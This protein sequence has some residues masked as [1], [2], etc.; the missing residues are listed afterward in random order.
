MM[1]AA[2]VFI[3]LLIGYV[4][5]YNQLVRLDALVSRSQNKLNN[6]FLR[7]RELAERISRHLETQALQAA[8][9][10]PTVTENIT[11]DILRH[12]EYEIALSGKIRDL[13]AR[14]EQ[15]L[16][17]DETFR[18]LHKEWAAAEDDLQN[19]RRRY[20]AAVRDYNVALHTFPSCFVGKSIKAKEKIF[21][22]AGNGEVSQ[23]ERQTS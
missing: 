5:F 9:I 13:F 6:C 8:D 18:Q 17:D 21:F 4:F 14:T 16:A 7:R 12:Q 3:V 19:I 20:N 22:K 10:L 23:N 15:Q 11:D 2:A 1:T